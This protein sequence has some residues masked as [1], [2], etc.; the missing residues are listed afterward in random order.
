MARDIGGQNGRVPAF[1]PPSAQCSLP[2]GQTLSFSVLLPL[3][4][5]QPRTNWY[6]RETGAPE[7][8]PAQLPT[9]GDKVLSST[10]FI[11][12]PGLVPAR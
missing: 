9:A 3:Q 12:E 10:R 11:S 2:E 6:A 1:D 7:D 5:D 8:R 4:V